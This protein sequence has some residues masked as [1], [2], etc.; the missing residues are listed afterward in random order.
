MRRSGPVALLAVV[1]V[2][3]L[4]GCGGGGGDSGGGRALV[5]AD[6]IPRAF[7]ADVDAPRSYSAPLTAVAQLAEGPKTARPWLVELY[8]HGD[9]LDRAVASALCAGMQQVKGFPGD[10]GAANWHEFLVGYVARF[11]ADVP[12][13]DAESM[14]EQVLQIWEL[15]QVSPAT[16]RA[17]WAACRV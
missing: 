9:P 11:G 15:G 12:A 16:A 3:G 4:A 1:A 5:V 6:A 7:K 17:Y 10:E 14:V 2:L 13:S 8:G